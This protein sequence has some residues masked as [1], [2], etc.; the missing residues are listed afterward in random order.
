M[1]LIAERYNK[2]DTQDLKGN[3]RTHVNTERRV[4]FMAVGRTCNNKVQQ[5]RGVW[6]W[7]L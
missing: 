5:H 3:T 2:A 7:W 4:I 6:V 1:L